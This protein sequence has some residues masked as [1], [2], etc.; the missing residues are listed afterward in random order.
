MFSNRMFKVCKSCTQTK[1]EP[2]LFCLIICKKY[3]SIFFS[4]KK[5]KM[6][7]KNIFI[8]QGHFSDFT[9]FAYSNTEESF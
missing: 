9:E 6:I 3:D 7:I 1:L 8:F 5:L 4:K 2:P